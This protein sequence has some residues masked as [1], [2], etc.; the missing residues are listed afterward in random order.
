MQGHL[1]CSAR[2]LR[3]ADIPGDAA[4]RRSG[5]CCVVGSFT[6]KVNTGFLFVKVVKLGAVE[7]TTTWAKAL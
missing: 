3:G 4:E 7:G 6:E 1:G 2:V 5:R